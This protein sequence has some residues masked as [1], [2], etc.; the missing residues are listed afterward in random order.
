MSAV[1]IVTDSFHAS[2]FAMMAGVNLR[3]VQHTYSAL[4]PKK[5]VRLKELV[6]DYIAGKC[7][8]GS[9]REALRDILSAPCVKYDYSR[10]AENREFSKRWLKDSIETVEKQ[11]QNTGSQINLFSMG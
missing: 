5:F 7:I 2:V 9:A 10:L 11:M 3:I 8:V 1:A 6:K 4:A